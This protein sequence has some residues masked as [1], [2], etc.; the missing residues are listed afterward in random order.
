MGQEIGLSKKNWQNTYKAGDDL[1]KMDYAVL[2]ERF[3]LARYIKDAIKL[4]RELTFLQEC[5][6]N[7][8]EQTVSFE[9][10]DN[11]AVKIS[12]DLATYETE[13][14][15]FLIFINPSL[16]TIYYDL[17]EYYQILFASGGNVLSSKTFVKHVMIKA[18]SFLILILK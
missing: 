5:D 9:D 4:R 14:K 16:E 1:N 18:R 17:D 6:L 13:F 2:D 7:K 10:L 15:D 12:Y 8:I 11:N 3:E